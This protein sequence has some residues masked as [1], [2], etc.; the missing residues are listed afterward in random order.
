MKKI[1]KKEVIIA[2]ITGIILASSIAV[3]AYSYY[4]KD[5]SYT[6]P[7]TDT[8]INVEAALNDLYSNMNLNTEI[9]NLTLY[10]DLSET[11]DNIKRRTSITKSF[12]AEANTIYYI[13]GTY[14]Y[15]TGTPGV[16][17]T[18]LHMGNDYGSIASF[19]DG[20]TVLESSLSVPFISIPFIKI[21][22]T[23]AGTVTININASAANNSFGEYLF[24]QIYK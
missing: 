2:F 5:I 17:K 22:T 12:T 14:T 11:A 3:Y 9:N 19:S 24:L 10:E 8:E 1:L 16:K 18:N 20:V 13:I 6:K 4:A 15:S 23:S 21:K 7:G